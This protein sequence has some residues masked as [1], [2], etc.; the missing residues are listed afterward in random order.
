MN[1][2]KVEQSSCTN[3]DS[4][5]ANTRVRG[6]R[7]RL[8][9]SGQI[10]DLTKSKTVREF[11][12]GLDKSDY[13]AE[14]TEADEK[15][16]YSIEVCFLNHLSRTGKFVL[17]VTPDEASPFIEARISQ[18]EV[19]V[20]KDLIYSKFSKEGS[21]RL[22]EYSFLLTEKLWKHHVHLLEAE[23]IEELIKLLKNTR[24]HTPLKKAHKIGGES[25]NPV[26]YNAALDQT[27]YLNILDELKKL[28]TQEKNQLQPLIQP[29][30]DYT[31]ILVYLRSKSLQMLFND[32][33]IPA[34]EVVDRLSNLKEDEG[35]E[36]IIAS[37]R[38]GDDGGVF[39][40]HLKN[41]DIFELE[42]ELK[43]HLLKLNKKT[44][45]SGDDGTHIILSYLKL[46]ETETQNLWSI[47]SGI[48]NRLEPEKIAK[49][50]IM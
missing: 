12:G 39:S 37:L 16:I 36:R 20:L 29:E 47:A 22:K 17:T 6:L 48:T 1:S 44:F 34:G 2:S 23:N 15:D 9:E 49:T 30:I 43:K 27:Y 41:N 14:L 3:L 18:N 24:Y 21:S 33:A 32:F 8:L 19:L 40:T 10:R 4:S 46:K 13:S 50:L 28:P 7:G 45:V 42:L 38:L 5:Y 11:L 31:N 26:P 35:V 25:Y